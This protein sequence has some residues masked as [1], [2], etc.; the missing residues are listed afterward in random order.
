MGLGRG[1]RQIIFYNYGGPGHYAHDCMNPTRISCWYS[2]HFDNEVE[3]CPSLI[4]KMHKKGV[5]QP[6]PTK[7]LQMMRSE[8]REEDP[9]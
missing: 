2:N 5:L 9:M 8:P 3:D 4:A 7:N 1:R 6:P